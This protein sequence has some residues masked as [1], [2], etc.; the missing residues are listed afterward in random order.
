MYAS[1]IADIEEKV[2]QLNDVLAKLRYRQEDLSD[3]LSAKE[4]KYY[5]YQK[6]KVLSK[7][8]VQATQIYLG[9]DRFGI[10]ETVFGGA[11]LFLQERKE[12][13]QTQQGISNKSYREIE[14]QESRLNDQL[15]RLQELY[16][17]IYA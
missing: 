1:P 8:A 13:I 3:G 4:S 12:Y 5:T 6:W 2:R 11:D 14:D 10:V 17:R 7:L 15:R 9:P 16:S